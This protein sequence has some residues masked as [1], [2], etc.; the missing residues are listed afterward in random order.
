MSGPHSPTDPA[1]GRAVSVPYSSGLGLSGNLFD[2]TSEDHARFQSPIHRGLGC[3]MEHR[4]AHQRLARSFSPLFIGAWVVGRR[5]REA[6]G[7]GVPF[8][9][10]IHRGLGCRMRSGTWPTRSA[11]RFQSPIHRGLGCRGRFAETQAGEEIVSVPYSSGLGL[12]GSPGGRREGVGRR[13]Q[14]PIHRG[15]GCRDRITRSTSTPRRS[16]S[17]PYSSGL[18]LSEPMTTDICGTCLSVSVPYS[19]GLGLS[20]VSRLRP[21]LGGRSPFQ[22][23][24]HRGLGCRIAHRT[25]VGGGSIGFSPLFIGA[26]VVGDLRVGGEQNGPAVSVPYSSGLGLSGHDRRDRPPAEQGF[27]PLFIGAWVVGD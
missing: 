7:P 1:A 20:A 26:W 3:R 9:S 17:V 14:S 8:Q 11:G 21:G 12:S 23:P 22:S 25:R 5:R 24:I 10:P 18:G 6:G 16:V 2:A 15:L 27:S 19:S 13:F 4:R